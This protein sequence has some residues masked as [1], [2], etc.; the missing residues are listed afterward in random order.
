VKIRDLFDTIAF[1]QHAEHKANLQ[2]DVLIDDRH[3]NILE[4]VLSGK[5]G[6]LY[7]NGWNKHSNTG[8][9]RAYNPTHVVAAVASISRFEAA[10]QGTPETEPETILQEAQRLVHGDRGQDYGHPI[11]D[12]TRTGRIW[13]AILGLEGAVTPQ[14]VALCMVGVKMSREVNR[15]KRDNRTDMAGYAETLDMVEQVLDS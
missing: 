11:E 5:Q 12:F 6:I 14:Q 13:G 7:D 15:P 2:L 4:W 10:K 1:V 3:E 8:A 9:L